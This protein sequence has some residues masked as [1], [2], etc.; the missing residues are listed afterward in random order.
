MLGYNDTLLHPYGFASQ[1]LMN[2]LFDNLGVAQSEFFLG[3]GPWNVIPQ[4]S[5]NS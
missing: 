1:S 2:D 3:Q 5:S 4:V